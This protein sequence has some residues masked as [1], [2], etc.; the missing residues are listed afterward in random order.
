MHG[1][2]YLLLVSRQ[3]GDAL[4]DRV[5]EAVADLLNPDRYWCVECKSHRVQSR[6]GTC[7]CCEG[8]Q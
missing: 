8:D 7:P 2:A 4:A 6:D 5:A 1:L 3:R